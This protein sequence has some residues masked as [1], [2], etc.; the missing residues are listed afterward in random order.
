MDARAA[1]LSR[2]QARIW[3]P[4]GAR[5]SLETCNLLSAASNPITR[6]PHPRCSD[7]AAAQVQTPTDPRAHEAPHHPSAQPSARSGQ[8][9]TSALSASTTRSRAAGPARSSAASAPRFSYV[10]TDTRLPVTLC[11]AGCTRHGPTWNVGVNCAAGSGGGERAM[12]FVALM[13]ADDLDEAITRPPGGGLGE[14][15]LV[16]LAERL[17]ALAEALERSAPTA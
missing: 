1:A 15:G 11:V 12:L 16:R 6:I 10:H 8:T 4:R 14:Q 9:R 2:R 7:G 13:L 17:E 3:F 5:P